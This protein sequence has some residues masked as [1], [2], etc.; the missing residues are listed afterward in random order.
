[1]M[2]WCNSEKLGDMSEDKQTENARTVTGIIRPYSRRHI[3][4][5]EA[6]RQYGEDN[7]INMLQ[8]EMGELLAAINQVRRGRIPKGKVIEEI[9]DVTIMI[10]QMAIIFGE[11]DVALMIENKLARLEQR[12]SRTVIHGI[13]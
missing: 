7:Q 3:I 13:G 8:E 9:A 11:A 12:L 1:M 2:I 5:E 10:E 4:C 6:V